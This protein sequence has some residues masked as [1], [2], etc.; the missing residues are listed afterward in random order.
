MV[1]LTNFLPQVFYR[2]SCAAVVI[3]WCVMT[4]LLVNRTYFFSQDRLPQVGDADGVIDRILSHRP[5]SNLALHRDFKEV[6]TISL[7]PRNLPDGGAEIL[8]TAI[9]KIELGGSGE[10][11]VVWRGE[12][13]LAPDRDVEKFSLKII[14]SETGRKVT[15]SFDPD[16]MEFDYK[17]EQNGLVLLDS[18]DES[19]KIVKRVKLLL[20][21]LGLSPAA[22]KR[23]EAKGASLA[24]D[25][26][27]LVR[28]GKVDIAGVRQ[29]VYILELSPTKSRKL[30]FYFSETGE[31][32]KVGDKKGGPVMGYDILSE[33]YRWPPGASRKGG[34]L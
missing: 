24:N 4:A 6:G 1:A 22:L 18:D 32:L 28:Y 16:E 13:E 34:A 29:S 21:P 26:N 27:I 25:E 8:M 17:V 14:F 11:D 31:L 2:I 30:K 19:S 15:L 9:G 12:V 20:A 23:K 3:F 7:T 5:S 10:Q 33:G